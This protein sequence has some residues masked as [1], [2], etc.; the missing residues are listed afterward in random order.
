[1]QPK[2]SK[3]NIV[4]NNINNKSLIFSEQ[5]LTNLH[6]YSVLKGGSNLKLNKSN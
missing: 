5:K 4:N 6:N 2:Y 1:M 3:H